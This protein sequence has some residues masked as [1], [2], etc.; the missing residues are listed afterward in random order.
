[1]WIAE[2]FVAKEREFWKLPE[3]REAASFCFAK[4]NGRGGVWVALETVTTQLD[5]WMDV[6]VERMICTETFI[7]RVC[8]SSFHRSMRKRKRNADVIKNL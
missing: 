5:G 4:W 2:E 6:A 7:L 3:R 1:V 8:V